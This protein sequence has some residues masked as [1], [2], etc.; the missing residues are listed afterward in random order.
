M[1]TVPARE[2][3]LQDAVKKR[4]KNAAQY[5]IGKCMGSPVLEY[6]IPVGGIGY[7]H[8]ISGDRIN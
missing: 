2:G 3:R 1:D 5:F 6:C 4:S 7:F 8:G